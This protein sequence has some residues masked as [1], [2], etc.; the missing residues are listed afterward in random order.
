VKR[1]RCIETGGKHLNYVKQL[2][3]CQN[4]VTEVADVLRRLEEAKLFTAAV[5]LQLT[6]TVI[7]TE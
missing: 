3:G 4:T 7:A 1:K 5:F 2:Y 6:V